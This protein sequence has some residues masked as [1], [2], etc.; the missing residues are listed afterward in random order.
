MLLSWAWQRISSWRGTTS[1]ILPLLSGSLYLLL[2]SRMVFQISLWEFTHYSDWYL[3]SVPCSKTSN[4][5]VVGKLPFLVGHCISMHCRNPQ[6]PWP[7]SNKNHVWYFWIG[8]APISH[9]HHWPILH[10]G[11]ASCEILFLVFRY[12]HW[13]HSGRIDLVGFPTCQR[14]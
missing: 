14:C 11:R 5:K 2:H 9:A 10:E 8:C 7:S 12:C 13:I 6:L 4:R 3:V 1:P